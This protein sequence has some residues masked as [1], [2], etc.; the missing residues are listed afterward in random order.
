MENL[1]SPKVVKEIIK[2]YGFNFSKSLGQNFLIDGNIVEK[3]VDLAEISSEDNVI[4][5]GPGIGTLTQVLCSRA[6]KV[7]AIEIDSKLIPILN[8][9]LKEYDN[10]K[11]VHSDVL[12][13][14]IDEL[15]EKELH[16]GN[17]KVVANLPYYVTTP[18]IMNLLENNSRIS[19]ITVMIQKE[20][21]E[22][23]SAVPSTKNY[24]ALSIAIQYH[25]IPTLGFIVSSNCF[26]PIPKVDSIVIKLDVL[27][28]PSVCV[29]D[30]EGFFKLIKASFGQ[31]RKILINSIVNSGYFNIGKD[32][33]KKLLISLE[34]DENIRGENL[35]LR[36]FA[37]LSNLLY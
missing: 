37:K 9:N 11:L 12:K 3:I 21:A 33:L 31:R 29:N 7:V 23:I 2:E 22:R 36:Q 17:V 16:S 24:G 35:S 1:S 18:I 6:K 15:I 28:T 27:E 32:D 25:S 14:D 10:F 4:E 19:S 30:K 5:I 34:L 26:M 20:V 13:I 8:E